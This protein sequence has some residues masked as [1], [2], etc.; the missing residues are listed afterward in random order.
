MATQ[1]T[2][3]GDGTF[4]FGGKSYKIT[5]D[6]DGVIFYID[7]DGNVSGVEGLDGTI[8]ADFSDGLNINGENIQVVGDKNNLVSVGANS[9]GIDEINGVNG[10]NVTIQGSANNIITTSAGTFTIGEQIFTVDVLSGVTFALTQNIVTSILNLVGNITGDFSNGININGTNIKVSGGNVTVSAT[11]E[12]VTSIKTSAGTFTIGN[13]TFTVDND[14]TFQLDSD[15]TVTGVEIVGSVALTSNGLAFSVNG[16]ALTVGVNDAVTITADSNGVTGIAGFDTFI[17]G[18]P[19]GATVGVT[20]NRV[21]VNGTAINITDSDYILTLDENAVPTLASNLSSGTAVINIPANMQLATDENGTFR[22]GRNYT[23]SGDDGGVLFYTGDSLKVTA[24]DSLDGAIAFQGDS[25]LTLNGYEV[26]IDKVTSAGDTISIYAGS[27]GIYD[28]FGLESGDTI[29]GDLNGAAI[30]M[31][32][33]TLNINGQTFKLDNDSDGVIIIP[34]ENST[35]IKYLSAGASFAVENA[36]TYIVTNDAEENA[37]LTFD[38][39]GTILVD[40]DGVISAYADSDFAVDSNS[41]LDSIIKTIANQ[42]TN[43]INL[44]TPLTTFDL[45]VNYDLNLA[46]YLDNQSA[47]VANYD[48][49]STAYR[50]RISLAGGEQN[51]TLNGAG[52]NIVAVM[53][54]GDKNIY[55][56]AGGDNVVVNSG[57]VTVH[58]GKGADDVV[59]KTDITVATNDAGTLKVTPL[60]DATIYLANYNSAVFN[61]GSGVQTSLT[62]ILKSVKNNS[63]SFGNGSAS[64]NNFGAVVFE[65]DAESTGSAFANFY[66][67]TFANSKIAFNYLAGGTVNASKLSDNLIIKGNYSNDKDSL[68]AGSLLGGSGNDTILAGDSDSINAGA[69]N[70]YIEFSTTRT[71]SAAVFINSTTSNDTV[72]NFKFGTDE[73]ADILYTEGLYVDSMSVADSDVVLKLR[74]AGTLTLADAVG[75]SILL[76]ND[77]VNDPVSIQFGKDKLTVNSAVEYYWAGGENASVEIGNYSADSIFA[78]LTNSKIQNREH[79]RFNGDIKTFDASSYRGAAHIVGND[80]ANVIYGAIGNS[81]IEGGKGNDTLYGGRGADLFIFGANHGEDNISNFDFE[82]DKIS[83]SELTLQSVTADSEGNVTLKLSDGSVAIENAVGNILNLNDST[84]QLGNDELIIANTAE[85]YY[86]GGSNATAF[87]ADYRADSVTIDLTGADSDAVKLLG[88]VQNIDA[89]NYEGTLN[90]TGN[91]KNNSIT[92]G[93]GAALIKY[94]NGGGNDTIYGVKENDSLQIVGANYSTVVSGDDLIVNVRS[95]S[96]LLKD[97]ANVALT[98]GGTI[99]G[100]TSKTVIG[101][102]GNDTITNT[103]A[104]AMINALAGND[105]IT[106]TGNRVSVEGGAGRDTIE[107]SGTNSTLSGGS[108]DDFISNTALSVTINGGAGYDTIF[109]SA[110]N[111]SLNAGDGNDRVTNTGSKVTI[112]LGKGADSLNNS[113]DSLKIEGGDSRD[114]IISSGANVTI[115]GGAGDDLI[116]IASGKKTLIEYHS[117]DDNDTIAGISSGDT[118]KITGA[119]YTSLTSGQNIKLKIGDDSIILREA[120]GVDFKIEG[121]LE[122]AE[123]PNVLK[124]TARPETLTNN[125]DEYI[126]YGLGGADTITNSGASVTIAGGTGND[127]ISNTGSSVVY[128]YAAGDGDDTIYGFTAYDTLQITR[129]AV[130]SSLANGNDFI[131]YIGAGSVT[132]KDMAEKTVNI[133]DTKGNVE[134][135]TIGK[136]MQGTSKADTLINAKDGYLIESFAGNDRITNRGDNCT[137]IGGTGNDTIINSGKNIVYRYA[138]A[139]GKDTITGFN[140]GDTINITRGTITSSIVSGSDLILNVGAGSITLKNIVAD[141]TV[142]IIN[143]DGTTSKLV[144]PRLVQGTARADTLTNAEDNYRIEGYAGTD[145]ITNGG[146]NCTIIGGAGNDTIINTGTKNL[147]QYSSGNGKDTIIGFSASDTLQITKGEIKNSVTNGED[148][149]L[150]I[151]SGAVTFKGIAKGSKINLIDAT[152]RNYSITV[153]KIL[154]GTAKNDTLKNT[155]KEYQVEGLAGNDS[156]TNS[157]NSCTI[158]GGKG[159]DTITNTAT[160]TLYRYAT[161]DGKDTIYGFSTTDT[162]Q[163]TSGKIKSSVISGDDLVLNVGTGSVTIKDIVG[164]SINLIDSSG[165]ATTLKVPYI[166]VLTSGAD[167]FTNE[168]ANYLVDALGGAD[169]IENFA[170]NVSVDGGAGKDYIYNSGTGSS[171]YGG[172]GNDSIDNFAS[173]VTIN[174]GA[175]NDTITNTGLKVV[176]EYA[177]GGGNDIIYGYGATDTLHITNG[178][179]KTMNIKGMDVTFNIGNGS[180]T[181]VEAAGKTINLQN[182]AGN[183]TS[184]VYSGIWE[185]TAK[186]D[187]FSNSS[188]NILLK[189]MGGNDTIANYAANVTINGG[190]GHDSITLDKSKNVTVIGGTGNDTVTS[191]STNGVLYQYANGDGKDV[192]SGFNRKDTIQVTNGTVKSVQTSGGNTIITIGTG[193]ITLE[194]YTSAVNLVDRNN[195]TIKV[196]SKTFDLFEDNNFITNEN[197]L[198]SIIEE[199]YSVTQIQTTKTDELQQPLLTF[200]KK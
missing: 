52:D 126:I 122:S 39:A 138:T 67:K 151:G 1:F 22:I 31:R 5:G 141:M 137:I 40:N 188:S 104:G 55:L 178:N 150:N 87:L 58:A 62:D 164:G 193:S 194:K 111:V 187:T 30:S 32:G 136:L 59:A 181:L 41:D 96:I 157:A 15:A 27:G 142:N 85:Y 89:T 199:K 94:S 116:S 14:A 73:T 133:M 191:S 49:S 128:Q 108:G 29:G 192:I 196:S 17:N 46:F 109:N 35:A 3:T 93:S 127:I 107:N 135:I 10:D 174:G 24:V 139:D 45:D 98:I 100:G 106:N 120:V 186:A 190:A 179:I 129:G 12:G 184:T 146:S 88:D 23:I 64:I 143:A 18:L 153:P 115:N 180:V 34:N 182:S 173:N 177:S 185:G 105:S 50:K 42:P 69:G 11:E 101:T 183:L 92:L 60:S 78:D 6:S 189:G 79:L 148:F 66:S 132:F 172:A 159:N 124:G 61:N 163:I 171:L 170:K 43:Y 118:L 76:E 83:T 63:I 131:L 9:Q 37:T 195:S 77:F 48:F 54:S 152:G 21:T 70:N 147:Y 165:T 169:T 13:R 102:A 20:D 197:N 57:N 168:D 121:T 119:K 160:K 114:T 154:Q 161:G 82:S 198:D 47:A 33:S 84:Y 117:G 91:N 56:G 149:T 2:T 134:T 97:A 51:L 176:Y 68:Y 75:K 53:G 175:G 158:I 123:D 16:T 125:K 86:A 200:A 38:G 80:S 162:L 71:K 36:G 167:R 130:K 113:G 26:A 99:E 90:L 103:V 28:V 155:E 144:I 72:K 166:H 8:S 25:T 95:N 65:L 110:T 140:D 81:S 156:I 145:K 19:A 74:N 112:L 44:R 4:N 7:D